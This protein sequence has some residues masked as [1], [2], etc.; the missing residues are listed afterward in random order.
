MLKEQKFTIDVE[1]DGFEKLNLKRDPETGEVS[2]D[3][4]LL[5]RVCEKNGVDPEQI[6]SDED[7]ISTLLVVWYKAHTENGGA[8]DLVCEEI[9]GEVL[10]EDGENNRDKSQVVW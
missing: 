10:L 7:N 5:V 8:L 1:Q 2:F 6:I 3:L 9:F 4:D